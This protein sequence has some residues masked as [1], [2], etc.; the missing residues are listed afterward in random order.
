MDRIHKKPIVSVLEYPFCCYTAPSRGAMIVSEHAPD[1][2]AALM[3][4]ISLS[5]VQQRIRILDH[6]SRD[7]EFPQG[8]STDKGQF[9]EAVM[10]LIA[11][12]SRGMTGSEI[13]NVMWS[14]AYLGF[15]DQALLASLV[16][17]RLTH[18]YLNLYEICCD[19]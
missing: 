16:E 18:I 3:R 17:V 2:V 19:D 5:G 8:M 10:V 6:I 7:S 12:K 9:M 1:L 14:L 15:H 4:P 13:S 11:S